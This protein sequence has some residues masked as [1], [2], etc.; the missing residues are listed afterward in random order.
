MNIWEWV[1]KKCPF[2]EGRVEKCCVKIM[3][4]TCDSFCIDCKATFYSDEMSKDK[5]GI[6]VRYEDISDIWKDA[7]QEYL[8]GYIS[9]W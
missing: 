7:T 4:W 3:Q 6:S 2:C 8:D 9:R 5:R 1:P